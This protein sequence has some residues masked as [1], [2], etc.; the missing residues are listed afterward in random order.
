MK[1]KKLMFGK[2]I[3]ITDNTDWMT[4]DIIEASLDWWQV[5]DRFRQKANPSD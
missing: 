1:Q 5:E 4:K 2:N 3:I